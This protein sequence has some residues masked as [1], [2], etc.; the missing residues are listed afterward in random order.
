[1]VQKNKTG[2]NLLVRDWDDKTVEQVQTSP[3]K[4]T[5]KPSLPKPKLE[6]KPEATGSTTLKVKVPVKTTKTVFDKSLRT[7]TAG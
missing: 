3:G 5:P 1:M 2:N 7:S 6:N 4:S